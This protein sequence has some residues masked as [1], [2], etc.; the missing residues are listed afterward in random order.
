MWYHARAKGAVEEWDTYTYAGDKQGYP[1][2]LFYCRL[3]KGGSWEINLS[4]QDVEELE[5]Q[6]MIPN[7][8]NIGEEVE[9]VELYGCK[10]EWIDSS[11]F[12]LAQLGVEEGEVLDEN[13]LED[14]GYRQTDGGARVEN[15]VYILVE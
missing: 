6:D 15:G 9:L 8:Y 11:G 7:I 3:W 12:D 2:T 1:R 14:H 4:Q 13:W 10:E 5:E